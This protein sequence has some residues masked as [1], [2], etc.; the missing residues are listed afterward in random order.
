ML[1]LEGKMRLSGLILAA[2]QKVPQRH[3]W[4]KVLQQLFKHLIGNFELHEAI[5]C[6]RKHPMTKTICIKPNYILP[7]LSPRNL[8]KLHNLINHL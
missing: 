7:S 2:L 4:Q 3:S 6:V 8:P 1:D 5:F